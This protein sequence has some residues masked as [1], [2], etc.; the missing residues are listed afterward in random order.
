M[1]KIKISIIVCWLLFHFVSIP[2]G[3]YG[4]QNETLANQNEIYVQGVRAF[5]EGNLS[6]AQLYLDQYLNETELD[7]R[8]D[9]LLQV[10]AEI[11]LVKAAYE[12]DL[13][14]S[15]ELLEQL[16]GKVPDHFLLH[17]AYLAKGDYYFRKKNYTEAIKTY[18]PIR[19]SLLNREAGHN[20][21]FKLAY[22]Y[23]VKKRFNEAAVIFDELSYVKNDFYYP[24]NYYL[25]I[26]QFLRSDFDDAIR[27]FK[28]VEKK[29]EYSPHIPY[30]LVQL[31]FTQEDYSTTIEYGEKQLVKQNLKNRY[32]IHHLLASAYFIQEDYKAAEPH[33]EKYEANTEKLSETDFYQLGYINYQLGQWEEAINYFLEI[34]DVEGSM[35]QN[36]NYYLADCYLKTEQK[37]SARN[38]LKKVT[39]YSIM[40]HLHEESLLNFGKLSAEMGY[41]REAID[42]LFAIPSNS[43]F[44]NEAQ[45][46]LS[47]LF[48]QTNDYAKAQ[49]MLEARDEVSHQLF[50]AYQKV[51]YFKALQ[52]IRNEDIATAIEDLKKAIKTDRDLSVTAQSYYWLAEIAQRQGNFQE[53]S[54]RLIKYFLLIKGVEE[55]AG[56]AAPSFAHYMQ[57]YNYIKLDEYQAAF[58]EFSACLEGVRDEK[59]VDDK[60]KW[61]VYINSKLR[62]AD[63]ALKTRQY[64][65]ALEHYQ[66]IIDSKNRFTPYA[67]FQKAIIQHLNRNIYGAISILQKVV[68]DY[69]ASDMVGL[70][71]MHLGDMYMEMDEASKAYDAYLGLVNSELNGNEMVN[72]AYLKLGLLAYNL[73]DMT[74]STGFYKSVLE[75]NP[76]G[77]ERKEA[78]DALEEIYINDLNKAGEYVDLAVSL[79]GVKLEN[80]YRDSLIYT[81]AQMSYEKDSLPMALEQFSAYLDSFP[82]GYF[83]VEAHFYRGQTNLTL[84]NYK[85]AYDDFAYVVD[86]G[87]GEFYVESCFNAALISF[88]YTKKFSKA[89]RHYS[90]LEEVLDN[91]VKKYDAQLGALRSAFRINDLYGVRQYSAKVINSTQASVREVASAHYFLGK[92]A[93][94]NAKYDEAIQAFNRVI[95]GYKNSTLAAESRYM[96]ALIYY[97][98]EEY[99]IAEELCQNANSQNSAYPYW[100]AKSLILLSDILVKKGD[101]FNAR[102]ALE[103]TIE[104]YQEDASIVNEAKAKLDDVI[105]RQNAASRLEQESKD[106]TIK[107]DSIDD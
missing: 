98:R 99:G 17:D 5:E 4:Q 67:L 66:F 90:A 45:D 106:G 65:V 27:S 68:Q 55:V 8:Q 42:A 16:E 87:P 41:D 30:Y 21:K 101:L 37:R 69:P 81:A 83:A 60:I 92:V 59:E 71:L 33:Y 63:C 70:S 51:S 105:E 23:F 103:A 96:I 76:S 11:Y 28:V 73:G 56:Q 49:Q 94:K 64:D 95:N 15:D 75:N 39:D 58:D 50:E 35:G 31:Y 24:A 80:L 53:S 26:C 93:Y 89:F 82:R 100:V 32:R 97:E 43:L 102:A 38:A 18:E 25:G 14:N 6:N 77:N 85:E 47:E 52:A 29:S 3:L 20:V 72:K 84:K 44:Y 19:L 13:E 62:A 40:N 34:S 86:L 88:N 46:L 107:M 57:G 1:Y 10:Q 22:S 48:V 61:Q 78:L 7:F 54:H 9:H 74:K 36:T 2:I 79:G 91:E 104:N 12:S